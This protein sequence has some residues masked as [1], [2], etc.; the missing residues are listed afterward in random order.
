V[1]QLFQSKSEDIKGDI[2]RLH[3]AAVSWRWLRDEISK[4]D[5]ELDSSAR[6][7]QTLKRLLAGLRTQIEAHENT[8]IVK[9][10]SAAP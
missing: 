8:G 7:D 2:K 5:S 6:G 9:S 4:I 1:R 3:L 10:E